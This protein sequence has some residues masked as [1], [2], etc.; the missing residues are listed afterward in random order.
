MYLFLIVPCVGGLQSVILAA[1]GHTHLLLKPILVSFRI[2]MNP[3][4]WFN[5]MNNC[6]L[7]HVPIALYHDCTNLIPIKRLSIRYLISAKAVWLLT[8][9][10]F[11]T[12]DHDSRC[13]YLR[14][15]SHTRSSPCERYKTN[16]RTSAACWPQVDP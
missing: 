5:A 6:N 11:R 13:Y 7:L 9:L 2:L 15:S 14:D 3:S 12:P 4:I 16:S 1:S 8:L 10:V